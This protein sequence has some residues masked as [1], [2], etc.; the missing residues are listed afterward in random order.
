MLSVPILMPPLNGQNDF[1]PRPLTDV[2]VGMVQ[3]R[4]IQH[5]GINPIGDGLI[6]T[7]PADDAD[8]NNDH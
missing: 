3:E 1:A 2:D 4:D 8:D 6:V 5:L 7:T